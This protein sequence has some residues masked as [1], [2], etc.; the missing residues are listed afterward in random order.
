MSYGRRRYASHCRDAETP[1]SSLDRLSMLLDFD[2]APDAIRD[3]KRAE[4]VRML[5]TAVGVGAKTLLAP[6]CT[7]ED[8]V[9]ERVEEDL[10]WSARNAGQRGLRVAYEAI[11]W[12]IINHYTPDAWRTVQNVGE[13]DLGMVIDAFHV[14]LR[15]R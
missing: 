5:D 9:A 2:G 4:A 7:N 8:C 13:A 12:S 11:A 3:A 6:A 1:R 15:H 14:F 10:R